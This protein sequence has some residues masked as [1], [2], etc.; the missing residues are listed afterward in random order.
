MMLAQKGFPAHLQNRINHIAINEPVKVFYTH[1]N[2]PRFC[3]SVT[4][5]S[6]CRC[7]RDLDAVV[8][9]VTPYCR[10]GRNL[11]SDTP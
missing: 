1:G 3:F 2:V 9:L 11:V 10:E 5:E 4:P 6:F 7:R 8:F